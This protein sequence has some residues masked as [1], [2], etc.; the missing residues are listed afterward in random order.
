MISE[1]ELKLMLKENKSFA[2]V[3][4]NKDGR[5]QSENHRNTGWFR[6]EGTLN[7]NK[8]PTNSTLLLSNPAMGRDATHTNVIH[9]LNFPN[10]IFPEIMF[11]YGKDKINDKGNDFIVSRGFV[12][13]CVFLL[14]F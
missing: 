1:I 11:H 12:I 8:I 13:L 2:F 9:S 5:N 7:S 4:E 14:T 3:I 6:L 10:L